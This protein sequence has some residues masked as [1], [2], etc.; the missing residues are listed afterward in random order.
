MDSTS[1]KVCKRNVCEENISRCVRTAEW[2]REKYDLRGL[3][4][5]SIGEAAVKNL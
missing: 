4:G 5:M 2:W 3:M 1:W